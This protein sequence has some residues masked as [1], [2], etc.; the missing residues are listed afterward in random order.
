MSITDP[1]IDWQTTEDLLLRLHKSLQ[2]HP[3]SP[4]I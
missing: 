1:C 3:R 2:S 4:P